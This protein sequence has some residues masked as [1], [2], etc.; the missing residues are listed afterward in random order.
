MQVS[1][2][3]LINLPLHMFTWTLHVPV[4][5][6]GA[7][8]TPEATAHRYAAACAAAH[9]ADLDAVGSELSVVRPPHEDHVSPLQCIAQHSARPHIPISGAQGTKDEP[10]DDSYAL[11]DSQIDSQLV[12]VAVRRSHLPA[13]ACEAASVPPGHETNPPRR[14]PAGNRC[15]ARP[16]RVLQVRSTHHPCRAV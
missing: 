6:Q 5:G 10:R 7:W 11:L 13:G 16:T 3:A 4:H 15:T 2:Y 1:I 14:R 8:R 12:L 9:T